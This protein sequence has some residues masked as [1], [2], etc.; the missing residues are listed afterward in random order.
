IVGDTTIEYTPTLNFVGNDSFTYEITANGKTDSATVTV[1]VF[2]VNDAPTDIALDDDHVDENMAAGTAVG[3]FSAIDPDADDN[4]TYTL[5]AD[6][7]DTNNDNA[8]FT[9]SDGVLKTAEIFDAETK[10]AYAIRVQ[11]RDSGGA[12]IEEQFIITVDDLN[13]A[14]VGVDD[15]ESTDE[16]SVLNVAPDG[17]LDNDTDQDDDTLT[18]MS[19]DS[20]SA[21]GASV[22]VSSDGSFSYDPTAVIALQALNVGQSIV[23]TFAYTVIDGG[24]VSDTATVNVTVTGVNDAPVANDDAET[25][26]L[27]TAVTIA[28]LENDADPDTTDTMDLVSFTQGAHGTVADNGDGTLTYTPEAGYIGDDSFTYTIEDAHGASDAAAVNITV[29]PKT[30]YVYMPVIT[31]NYNPAPDLVVTSVQANSETVEVVIENQGDQATDGGFWVDFY[32]NPIPAPQAANELWVDLSAEGI[33]WGV[34]VP[35]AASDILTLTY[36]LAPSA[37][38]LYYSAENSHFTGA[39]PAGTPIYAQADS[40]YVGNVYGA[41]LENHEITG[42]VYNNITQ[43]L[44]TI[45]PLAQQPGAIAAASAQLSNPLPDRH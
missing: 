17:V 44:A 32:V 39:L 28:P 31:N 42:G 21:Q 36:S 26:V 7:G 5:V 1:T 27:E 19:A 4:H 3:N 6:A 15:D 45:D 2:N 20:A 13:D 9:I 14:P 29:N 24:T 11:V 16:D 37:P 35:L 40:A 33:A 30:Y 25:T 18:V 41:I 23:D 12:T 8:S 10:G 34:T 43:G 38:N 22:N